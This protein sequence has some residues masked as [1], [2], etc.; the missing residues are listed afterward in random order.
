LKQALIL[1]AVFALAFVATV[2]LSGEVLTAL[3]PSLDDRQPAPAGGG[4]GEAPDLEARRRAEIARTMT[5]PAGGSPA[6][7]AVEA[8]ASESPATWVVEGRVL[9]DDGLA[10][11]TLRVSVHPSGPEALASGG[12]TI[13]VT[14]SDAG[15]Y[16]VGVAADGYVPRVPAEVRVEPGKKYEV[17]IL[18]TRGFEI[19]GT[20]VDSVDQRPIQGAVVDFNGLARATTDAYGFFHSELAA[21]RA[22]DRITIAHDD[23]DTQIVHNPVVPD[24]QNVALAMG[25]GKAIVMGR[26]IPAPGMDPPRAFVVR[27]VRHVMPGHEAVRR[28]RTFRDTSAFE[29]RGVSDGTHVLEVAFPGT[30][31]AT[32]RIP[33]DVER[34]PAR[35]FDVDLGGGGTVE[36]T[37][38]APARL[39]EGRTVSLRDGENHEIGETRT[40]AEGRFRFDHVAA[41]EYRIVMPIRIPPVN[42]PFFPVE[43]GRTTRVSIDG[44]SGRLA[45]GR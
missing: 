27:I 17:E 8:G 14:G 39:L 35:S 31:I 1:L 5:Q 19:R 3:K 29:I 43:D 28:E 40:D 15:V 37:F 33:F 21:P 45:V 2:L 23:Y 41:G 10:P 11:G 16:Q 18:L 24:P 9:T 12:G 22:L 6:P 36:G 34:D 25:R 7:V 4:G 42:T 30:T 26:V 32:R 20:V 44:A 38:A 13:R